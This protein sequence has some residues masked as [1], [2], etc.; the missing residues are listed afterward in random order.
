MRCPRVIA[1]TI[2]INAPIPEHAADRRWNWDVMHLLE[3]E[4]MLIISG[5]AGTAG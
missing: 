4:P 5:G 2:R 1:G 3:L